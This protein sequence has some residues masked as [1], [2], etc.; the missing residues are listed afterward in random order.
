MMYM[1]ERAAYYKRV[2]LAVSDPANYMS[3]I[4]DG[5]AQHHCQLPSA[6]NLTTYNNHIGQKLTGCIN[7]GREFVIFRNF[8]N[9]A[10]TGANLTI[11]VITT[12]LERTLKREGKLPPTLF[13][14]ID[15]GAENAN[16]TVLALSSFL[17]ARYS[18]LGLKAV[19]L[20]RLPPGHTHEDI[21]GKFARIWVKIRNESI[22][23]PSQFKKILEEL[24]QDSKLPFE[25]IDVIALPDYK[26]GLDEVTDP[27]LTGWSKTKMFQ[28][29][30]IFKLIDRTQTNRVGVSVEYKAYCQD[31]C[32][33]IVKAVDRFNPRCIGIRPIERF[34]PVLGLDQDI[35]VLLDFPSPEIEPVPFQEGWRDVMQRVIAEIRD[36]YDAGNDTSINPQVVKEWERFRDEIM[37]QTDCV[38]DYMTAHPLHIPLHQELYGPEAVISRRRVEAIEPK[39]K[40]AS[41][42]FNTTRVKQFNSQACVRHTKI[43]S[44]VPLPP[45]KPRSKEDMDPLTAEESRLKR[46]W[47]QVNV[48]DKTNAQLQEQLREINSTLPASDK[49][50]ISSLRNKQMKLERIKMH[51][52]LLGYEHNDSV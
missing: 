51:Y 35:N 21:D 20:T 23:T 11:H 49:I 34:N 8:N 22:T 30:W 52:D 12:M 24:F 32:F 29:Q 7:H 27:E 15:G 43:K 3:L 4:I 44:Q 33:N 48:E 36:K 10:K 14:Q 50:A 19:Y 37:P 46:L 47:S 42:E 5:M 41:T 6:G 28:A 26:T 9:L 31:R 39:G 38:S 16:T 13:I 1:G 45:L 18:N 25:M 2:G 17:V 40:S